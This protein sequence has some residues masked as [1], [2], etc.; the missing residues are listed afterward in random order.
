MKTKNVI[1]V[2]ITGDEEVALRNCIECLSDLH[3]QLCKVSRMTHRCDQIT[4][5]TEILLDIV[6]K[7]EITTF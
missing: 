3:E 7:G 1:K 2:T 4:K 5:T 6:E